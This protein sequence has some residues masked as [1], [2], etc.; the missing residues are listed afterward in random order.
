M[1]LLPLIPRISQ[2]MALLFLC[3]KFQNSYLSKFVK[4]YGYARTSKETK[5]IKTL[6]PLVISVFGINTSKYY[7]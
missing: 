4:I 1:I 7:A 3:N 2:E 6:M 5:K